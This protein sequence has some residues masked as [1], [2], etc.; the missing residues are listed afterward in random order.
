M[1]SVIKEVVSSFLNQKANIQSILI[2]LSGSP[3][4]EEYYNVLTPI[5]LSEPRIELLNSTI[6]LG[7]FGKLQ[8]AIQT[9]SDFVVFADDDVVQGEHVIEALVAAHVSDF[10]GVLGVRGAN[11]ICHLREMLGHHPTNR[12]MLG[13]HPTNV[14]HSDIRMCSQESISTHWTPES[15]S[16]IDTLFSFWLMPSSWVRVL[17]AEHPVTYRT[18]ED[19]HISY[20]VRKYLN[21]ETYLLNSEVPAYNGY[22]NV[23]LGEA[24]RSWVDNGARIGSE[25]QAGKRPN[26]AKRPQYTVVQAEESMSGPPNP[27]TKKRDYNFERDLTM[28]LLAERGNRM[29]RVW[30]LRETSSQDVDGKWDPYSALIVFTPTNLLRIGQEDLKLAI[31][32]PKV[33]IVVLCASHDCGEYDVAHVLLDFA[34]LHNALFGTFNNALDA[35]VYRVRP[36]TASQAVFHSRLLLDLST[37]LQSLLV[38]R[39]Q[40]CSSDAPGA[41]LKVVDVV[42]ELLGIAVND[43]CKS[44]WF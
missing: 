33:A 8:A 18:A 22:R 3:R 2:Y 7:Y 34:F 38:R 15:G 31:D 24:D 44:G 12:E 23:R 35:K 37:V 9:F 4:M 39:V 1:L 10:P 6:N 28:G 42:V 5:M 19:M 36:P 27:D 43:L 29:F 21:H 32:N 41:A 11:Y 13:H 25:L 26:V 20:M 40:T 16:T 17:F 30:K 14:P